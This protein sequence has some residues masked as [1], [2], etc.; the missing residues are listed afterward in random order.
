MMFVSRYIPVF[1]GKLAI[2]SFC[3]TITSL[4]LLSTYFGAIYVITVESLCAIILLGLWKYVRLSRIITLA[5]FLGVLMTVG[6]L[7]SRRQDDLHYTGVYMMVL[8]FFHLSEY[9]ATS[10]HNPST[11]QLDS[12][13]INHS[14]EYGIAAVASWIEYAIEFYFW[15]WMK[16]YYVISCLGI[17]LVVFGEV[18]RK[19]AMFTAMTNFTHNVQFYKRHSHRLVTWGVYSIFRHPSYVGWFYWSIGT[20]LLLGNPVCTVGYMMASWMFF[21]DRILCEEENLIEFFGQEYIDYQS[22]VKTGLPFIKGY[23]RD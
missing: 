9:V 6:I 22:K 1:E 23:I 20:Q 13:L 7:I 10:I 21:N 12:F 5:H 2:L 17:T 8:A 18:L 4:L 19:L 14:K 15:P 3:L 16:S 11:L